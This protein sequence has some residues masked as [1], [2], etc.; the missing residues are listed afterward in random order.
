[1]SL[2]DPWSPP[3]PGGSWSVPWARPG[4]SPVRQPPAERIPWMGPGPCDGLHVQLHMT[5]GVVNGKAVMDGTTR[6]VDVKPKVFLGIFC[7]QRR[8]CFATSLAD[9]DVTCPPKKIIRSRKSLESGS[10]A[11]PDDRNLQSQW[12]T[13]PGSPR[14]TTPKSSTVER[15]NPK[16]PAVALGSVLNKL[17]QGERAPHHLGHQAILPCLLGQGDR[18]RLSPSG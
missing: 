16:G 8:S 4:P 17:N 7:F 11:P 5:H 3:G 9:S 12:G 14:A 18:P 6:R 2:A 15:G 10:N 1:M 13:W